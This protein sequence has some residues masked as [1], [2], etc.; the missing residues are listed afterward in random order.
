[1]GNCPFQPMTFLPICFNLE[2]RKLLIVG[3][4]KVARA[5]LKTLIQYTNDI[6][7]CAPQVL[8]EIKAFGVQIIEQAY[9]PSVL[10]GFSLVIACT[11]DPAVN[12]RVYEDASARG[13][14][15]CIADDPAQG[16]FISPAIYKQ[17]EMSVAVS[18]NGRDAKR[19]IAWRNS[20]QQLFDG[21]LPSSRKL[22]SPEKAAGESALSA[23]KVWLVGFGPGDPELMTFKADRILRQADIIFYDSLIDCSVLERYPGER[24]FVGKRKGSHSQ[25]QEEINKLLLEAAGAGKSVVR[26]K[27]GDPCVFGRAGEE[28]EYLR[29]F[30]IPVEIVPGVTA[31]SAAAAACG[32]S[33]T[34]RG[35]S[36]SVVFKTAHCDPAG[37]SPTNAEAEP[38]TRTLVYYMGATKLGAIAEELLSQ[39]WDADTPVLLVHNASLPGQC[40]LRTNLGEMADAVVSS[41]IMVII[42]EIARTLHPN[43]T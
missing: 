39:R 16:D 2:D 33:L 6:T 15:T 27:G 21:S 4:G 8:D 35:M 26:L 41:P 34:M 5:K 29:Q 40:I 14:L 22:A 10:D 38:Q 17:G 13:L 37:S 24:V 12:H 19:S 43:A 30:N 31:A 23:G 3:G 7:V 18:S 9:L 1:V 36:R 25:Q 42:G 28:A 32:I 11:N 20:I